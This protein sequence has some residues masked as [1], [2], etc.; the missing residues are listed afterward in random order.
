MSPHR[1]P[2]PTSPK[3]C[4][5]SS[6]DCSESAPSD[7]SH[8][9]WTQRMYV[10][11]VQKASESIPSCLPPHSTPSRSR[12]A[13]KGGL[14][15]D[16]RPRRESNSSDT[17]TNAANPNS[18]VPEPPDNTSRGS[19]SP[20]GIIMHHHHHHHHQEFRQGP[21]PPPRGREGAWIATQ[22]IYISTKRG[23]R[24]YFNRVL[25]FQPECNPPGPHYARVTDSLRLQT[26][27]P[28]PLYTRDGSTIQ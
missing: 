11:T 9:M 5:D 15:G 7:S 17:T 27:L 16:L 8:N 22:E 23:M 1:A 28:D 21:L 20:S 24:S 13:L 10:R 6:L 12:K 14:C 18:C 2:I 26:L 4:D 25:V 19:A 3:L